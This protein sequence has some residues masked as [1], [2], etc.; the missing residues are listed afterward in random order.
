MSEE[1][2]ANE[3]YDLEKE[4][5]KNE[6]FRADLIKVHTQLKAKAELFNAL[7]EDGIT[8]ADQYTNSKSKKSE[9][10][11]EVSI[12]EITE[13][14]DSEVAE[15]KKMVEKQGQMLQRQDV[16]MRTDRLISEIRAEIK[17]KPEF[18]LTGKALNESIAYNILRAQE[19]DKEKGITKNLTDYLKNTEG[20]LKSFFTKLGG[21]VEDKP[22]GESTSGEST[23]APQDNPT[24]ND[25]PI[26]FPSLP[27]T[28]SGESTKSD[29]VEELKK[30]GT[31]PKTGRFDERL[32]FQKDLD[33]FLSNPENLK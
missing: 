3:H 8:T 16:Q 9:K 2:K 31:N 5:E 33:Q 28:G 22:A 18:T 15:L 24:S 19:A 4:K 26:D 29:P 27:A 23:T 21:K 11:D 10:E 30:L 25:G 6:K 7:S 20:E 17:D 32:A 14:N 1:Q 12:P 13:N